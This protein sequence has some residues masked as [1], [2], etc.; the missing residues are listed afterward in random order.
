[1]FWF[2]V[3]VALVIVLAL[4]AWSTKRA[5]GIH[6]DRAVRTQGASSGPREGLSQGDTARANSEIQTNRGDQQVM[7]P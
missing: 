2:W 5:K 1:M 4:A 3:G 7:G 6:G